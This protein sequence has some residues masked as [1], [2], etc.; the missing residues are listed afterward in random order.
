MPSHVV[1]D[2]VPSAKSQ[3][4]LESQEGTWLG[5]NHPDFGSR[6]R[7][8]GLGEYLLWVKTKYSHVLHTSI[9]L[10]MDHIYK[11]NDTATYIKLY[12]Q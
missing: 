9:L 8:S 3:C 12:P 5:S 6:G 7:H 1:I 4:V 10:T 11:M 2:N